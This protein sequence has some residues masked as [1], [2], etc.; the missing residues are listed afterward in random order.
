MP[1]TA[2]QI[3]QEI[4]TTQGSN[5]RTPIVQRDFSGGRGNEDYEQARPGML[6]AWEWTQAG[7]HCA[8]AE[9]NKNVGGGETYL[10]LQTVKSTN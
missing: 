10:P 1:R 7:E 2:M 8:V 5:C 6:T 9:G 3:Q 4:L